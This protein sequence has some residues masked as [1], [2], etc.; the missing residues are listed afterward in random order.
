[1]YEL[2]KEYKHWMMDSW[3]CTSANLVELKKRSLTLLQPGIKPLPPD[4]HYSPVDQCASHRATKSHW[5][6]YANQTP[7]VEYV[8]CTMCFFKIIYSHGRGCQYWWQR[9]AHWEW[10][11]CHSTP[12]SSCSAQSNNRESEVWLNL[13]LGCRCDGMWPAVSSFRPEAWYLGNFHQLAF[14]CA[15][16]LCRYVT[17]ARLTRQRVIRLSECKVSVIIN[18][19]KV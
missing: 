4:L 9:P 19:N 18:I 1:M 6:I 5:Q 17:S 11:H 15:V 14:C 10:K 12:C 2:R 13:E 7:Q 8:I 3:V 16:L